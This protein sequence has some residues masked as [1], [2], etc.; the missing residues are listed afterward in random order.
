VKGE[1]S[2]TQYFSKADRRRTYVQGL[3]RRPQA[4]RKYS[5]AYW[6]ATYAAPSRLHDPK[7]RAFT[8]TTPSIVQKE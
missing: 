8:R 3:P 7:M 6:R 5:F 2:F 1:T 4:L